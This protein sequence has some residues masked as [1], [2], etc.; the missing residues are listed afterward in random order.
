MNPTVMA[1]VDS[2]EPGGSTIK[3]LGSSRSR[4]LYGG[5]HPTALCGNSLGSF[6]SL[7]DPGSLGAQS[8]S[9]TARSEHP[10]LCLRGAGTWC[11][12]SLPQV[13]ANKTNRHVVARQSRRKAAK[14]SKVVM[15]ENPL[16]GYCR[17][18]HVA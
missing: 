7:V 14:P 8:R 10:Y 5:Q 13:P 1:A 12:G 11:L 3:E 17:W 9:E 18:A 2:P 4:S 16:N 6:L 15:G